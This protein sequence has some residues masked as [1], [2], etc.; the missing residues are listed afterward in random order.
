MMMNDSDDATAHFLP[1]SYYPDTTLVQ[2]DGY[3]SVKEAF[4][5]LF[6]FYD[7]DVF[8]IYMGGAIFWLV[9]LTIM[10]LANTMWCE[11]IDTSA[12]RARRQAAQEALEGNHAAI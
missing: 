4:F 12:R 3:V 2:P 10:Y 5:V 11:C 6:F 8:K 7:A 9:T 1:R